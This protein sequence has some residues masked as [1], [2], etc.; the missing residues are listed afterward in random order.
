MRLVGGCAGRCDVGIVTPRPNA[1]RSSSRRGKRVPRSACRRVAE[2]QTSTPRVAPGTAPIGGGGRS[3]GATALG[4]VPR[5]R[6][7]RFRFGAYTATHGPGGGGG[8]LGALQPIRGSDGG[9]GPA[10]ASGP[11][12]MLRSANAVPP[13]AWRSAG[14]LLYRRRARLCRLSKAPLDAVDVFSPRTNAL[15]FSRDQGSRPR[16]SRRANGEAAMRWA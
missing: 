8:E 7:A 12:P 5:R 4:I 6:E 3:R 15:S 16:A 11:R 14:S 9:R 13:A 1:R 2:Y 10:A